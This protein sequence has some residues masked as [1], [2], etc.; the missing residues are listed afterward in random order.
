MNMIVGMF[1][2]FPLVKYRNYSIQSNEQLQLLDNS[3]AFLISAKQEKIEKIFVNFNS[4][5]NSGFLMHYT[6]IIRN[7]K[8]F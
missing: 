8:D 3:E 2:P 1:F 5:A 4:I 7:D 6:S